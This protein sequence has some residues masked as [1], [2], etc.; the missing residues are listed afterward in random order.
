MPRPLNIMT[1]MR[2]NVSAVRNLNADQSL[3]LTRLDAS[4]LVDMPDDVG[5]VIGSG[6]FACGPAPLPPLA[7]GRVPITLGTAAAVSS[8]RV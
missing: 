1:Q 5:V 6:C 4:V 2:L 3:P 7:V 8:V